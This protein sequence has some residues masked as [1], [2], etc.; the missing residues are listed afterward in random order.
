MAILGFAPASKHLAFQLVKVPE[1]LRLSLDPFAVLGDR[2]FPGCDKGHPGFACHR[3]M[4]EHIA[5]FRWTAYV[6]IV[7]IA[8]A[9]DDSHEGMIYSVPREM[10]R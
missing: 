1:Q 8:L 4:R 3:Q 9:M 5:P 7:F 2:F 10:A 6:H